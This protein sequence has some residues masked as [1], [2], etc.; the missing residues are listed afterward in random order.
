[1]I[2]IDLITGFLG[3]G[4]TTF[5]RKYV[6]YLTGKGLKVGILENDYGA[7][8]VDAMLLQDV[9]GENCEL[10]MVAGGCDADCHRRRFKTKLIAMGMQGFDRVLVE[11]SGVFDMDEFFDTLHEDPL[12]RWYQIGN[13]IAIVDAH[14]E[15]DM[16]EHS[17]YILASEVANA[18]VLL[19]SKTDGV[20]DKQIND[21]TEYIDQSLEEFHC[22]RR[23]DN[24][25]MSKSWD[26]FG[27]ED[28][29][30]IENC[31]YVGAG[32]EKKYHADDVEFSSL[33]YMNKQMTVDKL[34]NCVNKTFSDEKCGNVFRIK[35]FMQEDGRWLELN[36][37]K[38]ETV[39]KPIKE[40]QEIFIVIGEDLK[41]EVID[42]YWE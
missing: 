21:V 2:K 25:V 5:I 19:F 33:Y 35:G 23:I 37:T 41:A 42:K 24:A 29:K 13:V 16:S 17:R 18:G 32:I 28:F 27:D 4:K 39:I 26:E 31:E 11:P 14:L 3:S 22:T 12:E 10:E 1:M 38:K 8:N 6:N 15:F 36:A 30:R 7:V 40:G 34:K 20:S 9:L